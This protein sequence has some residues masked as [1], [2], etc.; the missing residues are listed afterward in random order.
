[1]STNTKTLGLP[2]R[3]EHGGKSYDLPAAEIE[4][5]V[6]FEAWIERNLLA[7]HRRSR[8]IL[9][10][11]EYDRN[12]KAL[13]EAIGLEEYAYPGEKFFRALFT[14]KGMKQMVLLLMRKKYPDTTEEL[15]ETLVNAKYEEIAARMMDE[16]SDPSEG[17]VTQEQVHQGS[18]MSSPSSATNPSADPSMKSAA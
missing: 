14:M 17:L 10:Q 1:M 16:H 13:L 8:S 4:D 18:P 15:V 7:G 6:Q 2:T 12:G 11:D 9:P 5:L 3:L